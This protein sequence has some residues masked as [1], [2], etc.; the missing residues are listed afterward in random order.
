MN[1]LIITAAGLALM[2]VSSMASAVGVGTK[3]STLGAG[4]EMGVSLSK[5]FA[6]R[7][8]LNKFS[9]GNSQNISGIDYTADLDLNSVAAFLDFHP[10]KGTFHLTAGYVNSTSQ[11]K[12][13]ATPTGTFTVGNTPVDSSINPVTLTTTVDLGSGPYFG[14]G[15]GNVPAEG[16]GFTFEVGA[17]QQGAPDVTL[18]K[19]GDNMNQISQQ[20]LAQEEQNMQNDLN[21]YELYPVVALGVS[22]GF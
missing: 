10:F 3:A 21:A 12:G 22:Y 4:V 20:D 1:K 7:G 16:F 2:G 17:V 19:S 13:T 15:W 8:A 6:L 9:K 11:L 18:T 14:L 5:R